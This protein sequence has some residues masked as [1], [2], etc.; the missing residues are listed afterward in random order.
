MKNLLDLLDE[1]FDEQVSYRE[2]FSEIESSIYEA[3]ED[4]KNKTRDAFYEVYPEAKKDKWFSNQNHQEFRWIFLSPSYEEIR[5][6]DN[7]P[8]NIVIEI[9]ENSSSYDEQDC[10]IHTFPLTKQLLT[11]SGRMQMVQDWKRN[12]IQSN[13]DNNEQQK[14]LND[15]K[16]DEQIAQLE[17]E[18][19]HLKAMR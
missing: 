3:I 11:E 10:M 17:I 8:G 1:L 13:N 5:F 14:C 12:E 7:E 4:L 15:I 6:D 9:W 19:A 18:L 16:R 2:I